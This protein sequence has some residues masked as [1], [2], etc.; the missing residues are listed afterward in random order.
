[1]FN[2]TIRK[3]YD[4]EIEK[5]LQIWI[6]KSV[7]L[8]KK[9][10]KVWDVGQ[11]TKENLQLKYGNPEYFLGIVDGEI[12]GAFIL[13][14]ND[15]KYW[16]N[17]SDQAL[18]FH[19]FVI[20]D[21][22]CGLGYSKFILDWVKEYGKQLGKEYIRLDFNEKREYIKNMYYGNGFRFVSNFEETEKHKLVLAEYFINRNS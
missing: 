5:L 6:D 4:S 18:Y 9:G 13:I 8:E 7:S 12:F 16:G 1:M 14:A 2:A 19:K 15:P 17:R 20:L 10:I 22:Y 3:A 11:F 21:K